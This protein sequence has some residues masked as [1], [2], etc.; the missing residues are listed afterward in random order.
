MRNHYVTKHY[1]RAWAPEPDRIYWLDKSAPNPVT[2]LVGVNDAGV[3]QDLYADDIEKD[4][5]RE[6]E[7]PAQP[8]IDKLRAS[9]TLK[10]E[11]MMP[12]VRYMLCQIVRTPKYRDFLTEQSV[13]EVRVILD[14]LARLGVDI[15]EHGYGESLIDSKIRE[16]FGRHRGILA[17]KPSRNWSSQLF[18]TV[19][20]LGPVGEFIAG[21]NPVFTWSSDRK[22]VPRVL[23]FPLSPKL[24]LIG[25]QTSRIEFSS[26]AVVTNKD[27]INVAY[28]RVND[29]F[30]QY[31][32]DTIAGI[33]S[34]FL[35]GSSVKSLVAALRPAA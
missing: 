10:R 30:A 19:A 31:V 20:K 28:K 7:Q 25:S 11:E 18:W 6:V 33:A 23:V 16:G 26:V 15:S 27:T 9:E 8:L 17:A 12:L 5:N 34:R 4:F 1:L 14:A 32:N 35:Y 21:D 22:G 2:K 13:T 24:T 3:E 29:R